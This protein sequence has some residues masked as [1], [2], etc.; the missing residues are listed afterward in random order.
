M[1]G[2]GCGGKVNAKGFNDCGQSVLVRVCSKDG[3]V[4]GLDSG[5][6]KSGSQNTKSFC[7]KEG[8]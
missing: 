5:G 1:A 6:G 2:P 7:K 8:W 4:R 3:N